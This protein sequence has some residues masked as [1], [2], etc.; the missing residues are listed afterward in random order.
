MFGTQDW[1]VISTGPSPAS[2]P[3]PGSVLQAAS[4]AMTASVSEAAAMVRRR[5]RPER[6]SI[7]MMLPCM[8]GDR[9]CSAR[10]AHDTIGAD[11]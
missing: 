11:L 2:V 7:V 6:G 9:A 1:K 10:A 8:C 3:V 4:G 5:V